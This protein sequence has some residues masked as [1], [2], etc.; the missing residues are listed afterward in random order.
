MI[1]S[2]KC[3]E[4]A[5]GALLVLCLFEFDFIMKHFKMLKTMTGRGL[6]NLFLASMFLVGNNGE[7]WGYVML[8]GLLGVGLFFILVGCACIN[9]TE[10]KSALKRNTETT[11]EKAN[12]INTM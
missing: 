1:Y 8:G 3:Y 4:M 12:L 5:F 10:N 9:D 11:D 2:F 6:F 7:V